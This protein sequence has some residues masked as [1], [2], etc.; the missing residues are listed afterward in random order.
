METNKNTINA[1]TLAGLVAVLQ[2][3]DEYNRG[4][5]EGTINALKLTNETKTAEQ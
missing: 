2:Q 1:E 5:L 4:Y 3:A